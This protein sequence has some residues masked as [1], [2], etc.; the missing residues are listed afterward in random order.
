MSRR[1]SRRHSHCFVTRFAH[2]L[3]GQSSMPRS[4]I[5]VRIG[6]SNAHSSGAAKRA[7]RSVLPNSIL[8]WRDARYYA[9]YGEVELHLL[10]YLCSRDRDSIDVGAH[11]GCYANVLRRHS[12]KVIAFEPIPWLAKQLSARFGSSIEIFEVALSN[13]QSTAMLRV[14]I[15][16]GVDI[17]GCATIDER[18]VAHYSGSSQITV[19][20]DRLDALYPRA[21]GFIKIDVEGH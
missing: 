5:P 6:F 17:E 12:R 4:E 8:N 3:S 11:E 18:A 9:R 16:N 13:N 10:E 19:R 21:L 2:P 14:P 15:V 20:T 1:R 7:L